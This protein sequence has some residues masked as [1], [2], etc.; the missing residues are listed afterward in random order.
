VAPTAR[1]WLSPK[2]V[3][4]KAVPKVFPLILLRL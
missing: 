3:T 2:V 4:L 1:P